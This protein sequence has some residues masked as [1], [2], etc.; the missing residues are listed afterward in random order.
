MDLPTEKMV[1]ISNE[2]DSSVIMGNWNCK[3]FPT[4]FY[5]VSSIE[6]RHSSAIAGWHSV[7]YD[8]EYAYFLSLR[9][10]H[11]RK[12]ATG[13][14]SLTHYPE[15]F[16]PECYFDHLK[17]RKFYDTFIPFQHDHPLLGSFITDYGRS[18]LHV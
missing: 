3:E 8:L 5:G 12:K 7:K 18:F 10:Q 2:N 4:L 11:F 1:E 13:H 9:E 16:F 14:R 15:S 6:T 17:L